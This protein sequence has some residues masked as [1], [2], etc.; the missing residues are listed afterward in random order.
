MKYTLSLIIVCMLL[1]NCDADE[2]N[3]GSDDDFSGLDPIKIFY[4]DQSGSN[5]IGYDQGQT[6]PNV[7]TAFYCL[8]TAKQDLGNWFTA[9][10]DEQSEV[11]F[12]LSHYEFQS[13]STYILGLPT[14]N[15]DTINITN[16]N[17]KKDLKIFLNGELLYS[18]DQCSWN[19]PI[20]NI[21]K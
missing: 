16:E 13:N 14:Y 6:D 1:V 12:F 8:N 10:Q 18:F 2:C 17:R 3:F 7:V 9:E 5:L 21:V 19:D 4:F 11:F 20:V 15:P